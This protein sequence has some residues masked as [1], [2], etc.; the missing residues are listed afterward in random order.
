MGA[1]A[2]TS[3]F[4]QADKR[5]YMDGELAGLNI[6]PITD[7]IAYYSPESRIVTDEHIKHL[8]EKYGDR[9]IQML[10]LASREGNSEATE[11]KTTSTY[12]FT[13]MNK[14][15]YCL[16]REGEPR[17][18]MVYGNETGIIVPDAPNIC[19]ELDIELEPWQNPESTFNFT[20]QQ[21]LEMERQVEELVKELDAICGKDSLVSQRGK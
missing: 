18:V 7:L 8:N 15:V 4:M 21:D 12:L 9:K 2:A 5:R 13:H 1:I 6:Q 19:C 20:W 14:P 17:L 10:P 3:W 16:S 11:A